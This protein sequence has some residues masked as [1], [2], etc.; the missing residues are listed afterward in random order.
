MPSLP[1][2]IGTVVAVGLA[3]TVGVA[4][5]AQ[6][7]VSDTPVPVEVRSLLAATNSGVQEQRLAI[8]RDAEAWGSLWSEH[9]RLDVPS[10]PPPTV[11]FRSEMAVVVFLGTR[12]TGGHAV[13]IESVER[14]PTG[15]VVH[16]VATAPPADAMTTQ[17]LTSPMHAVAVPRCAG[18]VTLDLREAR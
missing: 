8:A 4:C 13:A 12:T 10:A 16:A 18:D 17:A 7:C 3:L 2:V 1:I 11:D 14:G 6:R 5:R 15:L 9:V